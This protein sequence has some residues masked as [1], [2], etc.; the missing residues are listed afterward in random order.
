MEI[1]WIRIKLLSERTGYSEEA[2][3]AKKKNGIWLEKLHWTKAPDGSI[4][5]NPEAIQSWIEGKPVKA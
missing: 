3:R 1:K 5:F 2:I 4:F